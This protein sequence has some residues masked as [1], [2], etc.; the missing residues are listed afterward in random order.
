M[1]LLQSSALPLGYPALEG[2]RNKRHTEG[3]G[4]AEFRGELE[5]WWIA[6]GGPLESVDGGGDLD[7]MEQGPGG[8]GTRADVPSGSGAID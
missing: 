6:A 8:T 5:V 2:P 7:G 3:L 1:E 4:K